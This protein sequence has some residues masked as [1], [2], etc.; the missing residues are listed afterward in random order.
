MKRASYILAA[1]I[2]CTGLPLMSGHAADK[3][4]EKVHQL[5]QRK[6]KHAQLILEG[7]ALNDFDKI[8]KNADELI[9]I[10]K[11][12]DWKVVKTPQY[13]IHSNDFRRTA[14]TLSL[15]AK[16]KNSDGSA[17]TYV[18]LTLSCVKCHKYVREVRMARLD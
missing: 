8:Q 6:L 17:L 4:E 15:M 9:V 11:A 3:G 10:S 1:L 12:A 2:L 14:E 7:I 5:M 13:D 16:G 18:E